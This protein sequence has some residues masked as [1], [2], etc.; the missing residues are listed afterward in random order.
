[1][2]GNPADNFSRSSHSQSES[3]TLEGDAQ[4]VGLEEARRR[5]RGIY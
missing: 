4:K 1:M 2:Q 3:N 5:A